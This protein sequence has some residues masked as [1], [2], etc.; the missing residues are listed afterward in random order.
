VSCSYESNHNSKGIYF[1]H[2]VSEEDTRCSQML[3]FTQIV[4][5]ISVVA[6]DVAPSLMFIVEAKVGARAGIM[7]LNN[8]RTRMIAL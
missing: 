5:S 1:F 3:I 6:N 8:Y 2:S 7:D 4:S